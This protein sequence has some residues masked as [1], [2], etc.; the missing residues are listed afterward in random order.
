[1]NTTPTLNPFADTE[2]KQSSNWM[3]ILAAIILGIATS[4]GVLMWRL[5]SITESVSPSTTSNPSTIKTKITSQSKDWD[6]YTAEIDNLVNELKTERESYEKKKSDFAAVE[7]R[8]ATEKKEL[9]RI[10]VEIEKM[11]A[12]LSAQTTEMQSSEKTNVRN[13]S[14]TY[15]NMKP[16]QAVAIISEMTDSNIVKILS[17]MKP[18][19]QARILAEMAKTLDPLAAGAPVPAGSAIATLAP[20]AAK[21]T[22]QLRLLKQ[23]P[24]DQ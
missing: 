2:E 9:T 15:S 8:I 7:L 5:P 13:L 20:R 17:L 3:P 22:D 21:L 18:D 12:E 24:A 4:A 14:R 10:R 11:R 1:M 6:F 19:I 23:A 16:E